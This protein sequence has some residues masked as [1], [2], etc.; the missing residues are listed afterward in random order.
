MKTILFALFISFSI[1]LF[2]GCAGLKKRQTTRSPDG[3][4]S[5]A[6]RVVKIGTKNGSPGANIVLENQGGL[7]VSN[8]NG[9]DLRNMDFTGANLKDTYMGGA[10]LGG[11]DLRRAENAEKGYFQGAY[12]D[13]DTK[14]PS[15][16]VPDRHGMVLDLRGD[17]IISINKRLHVQRKQSPPGKSIR[18]N[19]LH[20]VEG[21][22]VIDIDTELPLDFV[23]YEHGMVLDL[24]ETPTSRILKEV[25][26]FRGARFGLHDVSNFD[27]QDKDLHGAD[28]RHV[29]HFN[30]AKKGNTW[31][32]LNTSFPRHFD[33]DDLSR[34]GFV[35]DLRDTE[36]WL[37]QAYG[38]GNMQLKDLLEAGTAADFRGARSGNDRPDWVYTSKRADRIYYARRAAVLMNMGQDETIH[39]RRRVKIL[40]FEGFDL[41]S[42]INLETANLHG[43]MYNDR[44]QFPEGFDPKARGLI[45]TD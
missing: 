44:T 36:V 17:R 27:F 4:L 9:S 25:R 10:H 30:R 38:K 2:S 24:S 23:P 12:Y 40:S 14:F 20:S 39:H 42:A 34:A 26:D 21:E 16:F 6:K 3:L 32:D 19:R 28:L 31:F 1:G 37:A 8:L 41:R 18:L 15:D 43:V 5:L 11:A 45:K 22:A 29:S 7:G 33:A 35:L 13:M